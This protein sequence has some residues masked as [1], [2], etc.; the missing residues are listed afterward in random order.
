MKVLKVYDKINRNLI[1]SDLKTGNLI[2][3]EFF[4]GD[5]F[6]TIIINSKVFKN[7]SKSMS[8]F[9]CTHTEGGI[10]RCS[11]DITHKYI[12]FS[13]INES[14]LLVHSERI[15]T[16]DNKSFLIKDRIYDD[17]AEFIEIENYKGNRTINFKIKENIINELIK[18][19]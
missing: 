1:H 14:G 17:S 13:L 7:K 8:Y 2:I 16:K 12:F 5:S 15:H 3:R 6:I 10:V 11:I 9:S 4:E 18:N 19:T